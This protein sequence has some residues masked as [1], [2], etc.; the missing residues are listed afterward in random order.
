MMPV[1][2]TIGSTQ[3]HGIEVHFDVMDNPGMML[4]RTKWNDLTE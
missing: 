3:Y 2:D 4:D 1:S